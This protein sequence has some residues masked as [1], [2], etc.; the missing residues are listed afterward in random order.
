MEGK[1]LA[2]AVVLIIVVVVAIVF[3]AKRMSSSPPPPSW[4]LDTKVQKID[5]KTQELFTESNGDWIG[6][7]A[8]DVTGRYKN[9]KTG[10]CTL[11][12]PMKCAACGA[13]ISG[14]QFYEALHPAGAAPAAPVAVGTNGLPPMAPP[15]M[16]DP[17]VIEKIKS[18][19][20]CPKCGKSPFGS[21]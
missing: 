13:T 16:V 1:K 10:A 20:R 19:Y 11:V 3:A 6:K 15:N 2:A 7:Y 17:S 4:V 21:L 8:P 5:Y 9:P 12:D 14:P 18:E